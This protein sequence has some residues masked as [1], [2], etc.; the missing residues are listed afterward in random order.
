[1][2][3]VEPN[4]GACSTPQTCGGGGTTNVCGTGGVLACAQPYAQDYCLSFR[5]GSRV[6]SGGH[7]WVCSD[8]NCS[9]CSTDPSCE[10]GGTGC[11]WGIVWTDEGP[12][13]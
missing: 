10:P 13:N 9:N 5:I 3:R 1:M 6:S 4:C 12:C 7:D 11:P 8:N 2:P